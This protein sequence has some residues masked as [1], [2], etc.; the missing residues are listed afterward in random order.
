ME[1]KT[2]IL[3]HTLENALRHNGK[4]ML[5]PVINRLLGERPELRKDIKNI[6]NIIKETIEYV[7]SLT[8]EKQ[9]KL[10]KELGIELV[11]KEKG[12]KK[13]ELPPLP[14]AEK[15]QRIITRFAPNPDFVLHLGSARPAILSY[16][17]ARKY[18]GKFILRF[19][20]T[21]PRTKTPILQA[22]ELIKE[23]LKWLGI[24]WDE[25]YIQSQ[26]LEIYYNY[27]K[28]LIE[29]GHAYV[30][31]C[32][33][34]KIREYRVKGIGDECAKL[35][36]ESQLERW[37]KM[38]T[39]EYDE[40]E[41]VLRIKTNIK[42]PDPSV[43]DWIAFRIID[44]EKYPHPLTGSKYNVWPTY[45]FACS[46]DDHLQGIT[47][48]LRAK[49]HQTNTIKQGYIYE[50][51]NWT[52]PVTIHF[53][54][55]NL[56]GTVLS[57][58]KIR[59]GIKKG[60]YQSWDDPRLGTLIALRR[61]GIL[62][63]AIWDL[64]LNVGIKPSSARISLDNLHALNRRYL[65]DIANRYMFVPN[66]KSL[67]IEYDQDL[68]AVIPYHPSY[69]ERGYRRIRLQ[70]INGKLNVL[71]SS[72]DMQSI[73]VNREFRLLGLANLRLLS[74]DP[75]EAVVVSKESEYAKSM[76]L[77]IIQWCPLDDNISVKVLKAEKDRV[78]IVAGKAESFVKQLK[79]GDQ[80]QFFRFG[81]V[82]LEK[83]DGNEAFFVYTHN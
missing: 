82:K 55:L 77:P 10:A 20:D 47:H 52:K 53:G 9:Q 58:S 30:C 42:Y 5:Q 70:C 40:G 50:Y 25:E 83:M 60:L 63:K 62:P 12:E 76:K 3:R 59:E 14:Y 51:F 66:P 2:V 17:Y 31:T 64:I 33:P 32:P 69:P 16:A 1:V 39:G 29:K 45:N 26:R 8:I 27:A 4:A 78:S 56:E 37:E 11:E 81:F 44:T 15:F 68:K 75:L 21:D 7:N 71:V 36:V 73:G 57:K 65:E 54:R 48:I 18:N 38:L 22:Y 41:A 19:E 13:K 28:Q 34:T 43:R 61:R 23:D 49:E 67:L 6:I 74:L 24:K 80:I 72:H 79:I 46:I 35:P